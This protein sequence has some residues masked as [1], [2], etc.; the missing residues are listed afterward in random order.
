MQN[1]P[2]DPSEWTL[3]NYRHPDQFGNWLGYKII[4]IDREK[5]VSEVSLQIRDDHLS[6]ARRVHGGVNS[7]LFDFTCGAAVFSTLAPRDY[8]STVELKINYLQPIELGDLLRARGEV[9]F[10]GKR[11]CVVQAFAYRNDEKQPVAMATSTFNVV[12]GKVS[13][14]PPT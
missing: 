1:K 12:A 2:S 10:R 9:I 14:I 11:L 8:G 5:F 6:P 4:S 7:S 3:E 13:P